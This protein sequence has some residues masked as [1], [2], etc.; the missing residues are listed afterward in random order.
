MSSARDRK[1]GV[2]GGRIRGPPSRGGRRWRPIGG[3]L[4]SRR[5]CSAV[6]RSGCAVAPAARGRARRTQRRAGAGRRGGDRQ[7]RPARRRRGAGRRDADP[8]GARNRVRGR[9][10][11]R[12][13]ARAPAPGARRARTRARR[14]RRPRC[15]ARS[16]C[17][18]AVPRTA[19]RSAPRRSACSPPTPRRRPVLVLVDDAH[20]LDAPSAEALLFAIRRLLADPV[21][22][23]LAVREG[24]ASLLD[25]ADLPTLEVGGLDR[26]GRARAARSRGRRAR[27]RRCRRPD[28]R[29][30]RRQPAGAA[31]G[32]PGGGEAS[33]RGGLAGPVPVS[34][35]I[36]E[37]FL[38]RTAPLPERTRRA[39]TL[40]A[41]SDG[42]ELTV[43]ARAARSS[44]GWSSPTSTPGEAAGLVRLG[45]GIVEFRHPLA[46]AAI[47]NDAIARG[48]PA[49][50]PRARRRAARPRRRPAR[51]APRRRPPPAPTRPRAPR[52]QQAA[53]RARRRGAPTRPPRAAFERA[54][55]LDAR[56]RRRRPRCS[57]RPP[58]RRGSAGAVDRAAVAGRRGPRP[59]APAACS[60]PAS[61]TPRAR[62]S[63]AADR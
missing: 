17:A 9:R 1:A 57:T 60:R 61:S 2:S 8:P 52:S 47:Y 19:S 41:A 59:G 25:G 62:S 4:E 38:H 29:G 45:D 40:A 23:V 30:D 26:R 24:H 28:V 14:R 31:R 56:G 22:V 48:A 49:G 13:A 18:R 58:T 46:R 44:S 63:S 35:R 36:T 20:W 3:D 50:A 10:P 39:L 51:L 15:R 42:G 43:L 54:A 6:T 12:R 55:R 37:A 5:C 34:R 7:D 33:P 53:E 27:R 21:A 16:R 11:V 32:R